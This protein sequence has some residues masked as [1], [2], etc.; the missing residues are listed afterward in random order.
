MDHSEKTF[1]LKLSEGFENGSIGQVREH[2]GEIIV[3]HP[4]PITAGM[5]VVLLFPLLPVEVVELDVDGRR[6]TTQSL[7][8][9]RYGR[10]I[11]QDQSFSMNELKRLRL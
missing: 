3:G 7:D 9:F 4:N 6:G 1:I 8:Q 2:P 11:L 10:K 5:I